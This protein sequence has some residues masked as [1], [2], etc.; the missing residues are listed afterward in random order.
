ML[1]LI[2]MFEI[3]PKVTSP[4]SVICFGLA[5]F[6]MF[7]RS[8][9]RKKQASLGVDDPEA[10]RN[11]VKKILSV[12]PNIDI[13]P[14]TDP[15]QAAVLAGDI[16]KADLAK[17]NRKITA[18]LIFCSIFATVFLLSLL[19][20]PKA[21][22]NNNE[23]TGNYPLTQ[24]K[25]TWSQDS[26]I[27]NKRPYALPAVIQHVKL[28]CKPAGD[29]LKY[30]AEF[31]MYYTLWA[32][33]DINSH[34]SVFEEQFI[35]SDA[36][37]TPWAGTEQQNTVSIVDGRYWV[38]FD[39]KKG[40]TKTIVTGANYSYPYSLGRVRSSG[41][42][43]LTIGEGE[44]LTCYPN[45]LDYID[46]L[47]ILIESEGM[48]TS[49]PPIATYRKTIQGNIIEGEGSCKVYAANTRCTLIGKWSN[50]SPGECVG[51]KISWT[52]VH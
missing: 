21:V 31:R 35:S 7:K 16:I 47:T 39:L 25:S 5:V 49:L 28:K 1:A 10:K 51:L 19:I 2:N 11:A 34:E 42:F 12:Y 3:I 50:L 41:C 20:P 24:H 22:P 27:I 18:L 13:D 43:N 6:F 23:D 38:K 32:S 40:E 36:Q 4:L 30:D 9:D 8:E 26:V 29:S 17:H 52:P 48:N 33:R 46:N 45:S 14:I 37:V 15:I 44:W